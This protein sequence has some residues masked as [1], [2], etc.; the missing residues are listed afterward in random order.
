MYKHTQI[1][2]VT[3]YAVIGVFALITILP[4]PSDP[5]GAPLLGFLF[6]VL[7]LLF[8]TLTISVEGGLL[9]VVFGIGLV[10][11]TLSLEDIAS[12]D[13]VRNRWWYGF[14]IHGWFGKGWL[15]NVSGLDA[16]ELK[17]KNGMLYRIGTDQ[18]Q[19]LCQAICSGLRA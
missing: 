5:V 15:L 10:R 1:G 4:K 11:K 17:M 13:I 9:R 14:G 3:I 8:A 12:A 2:W 6:F 18:P 7:L 19:E 16:V